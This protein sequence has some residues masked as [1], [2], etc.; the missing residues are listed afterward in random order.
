MTRTPD[1][2]VT[3]VDFE[4]TL[5]TG[6]HHSE[7]VSREVLQVGVNKVHA[8]GTW[9]RYTADGTPLAGSDITYILTRQGDRWGVQARFAA[10]VNGLGAAGRQRTPRP[11]RGG[12]R[13]H[14]GVELRTI[15]RRS[16][17]RSTTR[18]CA[19]PTA[20]SRSGARPPTTSRAR[21]RDA[22][23]RG[24]RPG[25]M[26]RR[27]CRPRRPASTWWCRSA[28][29]GADGEVLSADEGVFLAVLRDGAWKVQARSTF[30]P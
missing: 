28:G 27:P 21:S 23:A 12:A 11:P 20:A 4:Q 14:S 26:R 10:G 19:S 17:P 2:Y 22:S 6:W 24:S 9:Q 16:P 15:T 29:S 18:T 5:K 25:S 30:G 1:E 13:V 8:S 7:W 3:G